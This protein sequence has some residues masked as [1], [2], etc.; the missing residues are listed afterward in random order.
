MT[1]LVG[2]DDQDGAEERTRRSVSRFGVQFGPQPPQS[3]KVLAGDRLS[4]EGHSA[5]KLDGT[6]RVG[7]TVVIVIGA[8][9]LHVTSVEQ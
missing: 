6:T 1:C 7:P 8:A 9:G 2:A 5:R 3:L 4:D